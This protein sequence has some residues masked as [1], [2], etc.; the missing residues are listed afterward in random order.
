MKRHFGFGILALLLLLV[1]SCGSGGGFFP[2]SS[3]TKMAED[4]AEHYYADVSAADA[5]AQWAGPG[6]WDEEP[7][8]GCVPACEAKQCGPDGCG[9]TCGWCSAQTSCQ[10]GVCVEVPGCTPECAGK[11]IGEEDGCGGVCSG[12][13]FGIGLKPGGAQDVGY[14]RKLVADGQVPEAEFFPIEGFLNEHDTPLPPPN[15]DMLATLHA[16]V[17]LFYDPQVDEP[18]IAMQL[19]LNSG[20]D[21]SVISAKNFNLVVVVDVSG[22]MASDSKLDFVREGLSLMLDSLDENDTLGIVTY[23]D[24]AKVALAPV[25]VTA[26][27]VPEIQKIID[28]LAP[29][30]STNIF[31][32]LEVGYKEAMKGITNG[33]ALHRVMLL[34]DGLATAGNTS[35]D[36]ILTMSA[37]YNDE[38]IGITTIGVGS[39]FNFELMYGLANQGN[40]NFYFLEDG[41][42]LVDVFQHELEYLM[43]PVA[44][45]LK[46]SFT[47]PKGF[48]VED[49]YGFDF[50]THE[51]GE[52]VLLG[53]SPQY[54]VAPPGETPGG[55]PGSGGGVAVSTL[56][57]SKKNGILMVKIGA[58]MAPDIFT[59]WN[60]LDF[61]K[62]TYSYELVTKG[63]TE[64]GETVVTLGSLSY[65]AEDDEGPL[66]WFSG[67][68]MQRNFCVLRT[69]LAIRQACTLYHQENRDVDGA[70]L[71]LADATTFC[72]GINLQ[73]KDP[74]ITEDVELMEQ[75]KDNMCALEQCMT[76]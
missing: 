66:A 39:D 23:D 71:Q 37:P 47:L 8:N 73:L 55:G 76:P 21:P 67:P 57:A 46:I 41:E 63:T 72:N 25:P 36:A 10:D 58:E 17:G 30:G 24:V 32:G 33:E 43:T 35:T 5:A 2:S 31:K 42:K 52:V 34:S 45:N 19:G 9:G 1:A 65:F 56:F 70:I 27:N 14:F 16:F 22:S 7:G 69:A 15:Y 11:M 13:G 64:V 3:G 29:G 49:I 53:P 75:V 38:G 68:I 62:V 6:G 60:N 18:L 20:L 61:A 50:E 74:A 54:S 28:N 12:G 59:A 26:A 4:A 48:F 51:G 40:G 44:E